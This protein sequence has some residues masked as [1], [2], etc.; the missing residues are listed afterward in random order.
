MGIIVTEYESRPSRH[1]RQCALERKIPIMVSIL[2]VIS[3]II[4]ISIVYP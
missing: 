1:L 2:F 4:L 3:Y